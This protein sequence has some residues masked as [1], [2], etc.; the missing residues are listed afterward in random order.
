[1]VF[2]PAT[3][4][5][6]RG[7]RIHS[8]PEDDVLSPLPKKTAISRVR[9]PHPAKHIMSRISISSSCH[10]FF[11]SQ[12]TPDGEYLYAACPRNNIASRNDNKHITRFFIF[13]N[14]IEKENFN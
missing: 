1:M 12:Y 7:T 4:A 3:F 5:A 14:S 8:N 9:K 11:H 2:Y 6:G 13:D 10:Q